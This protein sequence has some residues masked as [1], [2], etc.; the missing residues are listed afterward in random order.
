MEQQEDRFTDP[1]YRAAVVDLLGTLAYGELSAFIRLSTDA[2]LAPR[3]SAKADMA[4]LAATEFAHYD[5]LRARLVEIGADPEQAMAPFVE[6]LDGFHER[7]RP[8]DWLEGLVKFYVGDGIASDFYR[9]I[10]TYVDDETRDLVLGTLEAGQRMSFVLQE[11]RQAISEDPI[12][13]SR[14]ALWGRRLVGEALSQGQ[15]VA[16]DRDTFST[17]LTGTDEHPGM[18]LVGIVSMFSRITE[19][20]TKRMAEMGLSA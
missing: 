12:K 5:R 10:S 7:T 3:L 17:L 19:Q 4:A 15:R 11:V 16:A 13:G 1:A 18:G 2:D 14:L 20:H 6:A 9:E 8:S